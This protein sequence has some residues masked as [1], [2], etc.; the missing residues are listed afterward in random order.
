MSFLTRLQQIDHRGRGKLASFPLSPGGRGYPVLQSGERGAIR[1]NLYLVFTL[2][3]VIRRGRLNT[4]PACC[5]QAI[6]GEESF[7]ISF[8]PPIIIVK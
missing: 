4:L 2:S 5:R 3:P 6:K 7:L 8:F 1:C